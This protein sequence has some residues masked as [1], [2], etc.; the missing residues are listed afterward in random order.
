LGGGIVVNE[1]FSLRD[2]GRR[3]VLQALHD[4]GACSRTELIR[5][6]RLSRSTVSSLV[7]ELV[8]RGVV[9]EH[10]R[11]SPADGLRSIGRPAVVVSMA[12]HAGYAIGVDIGHEHVRVAV[13]GLL[14]DIV[15]ESEARREVDLA[16]HETLDLAADQVRQAL[17]EHDI[18]P[19]VVIG[20]GLDIAA[21]VHTGSGRIEASG[22]MPGWVGVNPAEEMRARTGLDVHVINDADAGALG[23]H[24]YGA[25]R[26]VDDL[27]YVRLSAGI[28]A[29]VIAGRQPLRGSTGL[30]GEL[31]HVHAIENGTICRCG[32]RGCLETVAS[33]PAIA[34]LLS[35]SWHRPVTSQELMQLV[36]DGDPGACRAV[37]DAAS[38][39]GLAI[40]AAVNVLNPQLVVIGG[41]LAPA[42]ELLLHPIRTA[43]RR[44][45]LP[46][47]A[48]QVT[49]VRGQ[50]GKHAEV[51]GAA[52][53]A[54]ADM[55]HRLTQ[56]ASL[57]G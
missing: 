16:P 48:A 56:P 2:E 52:T 42:G 41:D 35:Q 26:G 18:D 40:A 38:H 28:G 24:T 27:L 22:I 45:V 55:P 5:L 49:V 33:P 36:Y 6:T 39:V 34:H 44:H 43:V 9:E 19:A 47:I 57:H 10:P 14:G 54:L 29:A 51:L 53:L 7:A 17:A 15:A 46:A 1:P 3:R 8:T 13:C 32:N 4:N 50:L 21:P 30:A 23:E 37:E 12:P 25:A 20:L 31:G 11:S